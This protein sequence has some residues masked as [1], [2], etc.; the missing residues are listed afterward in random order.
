MPFASPEITNAKTFNE[1]IVMK[2][3]IAMRNAG[4]VLGTLLVISLIAVPAFAGCGHGPGMMRGGG[5]GY[6]PYSNLTQEQITQ[7]NALHQN[8][9]KDT[10][11]L[12]DDLWAKRHD[13]SEL[14]EASKPDL[15]KA[16][17]LQQQVSA[18]EA[19]IDQ[20]KIEYIVSAHKIAPELGFFGL[21]FGFGHYRHGRHMM[22]ERGC[23]CGG[24]G[25]GG[26]WAH[27]YGH[28]GYGPGGYG[29]GWRGGSCSR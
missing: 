22:M 15:Q 8:F 13:L 4:I 17:D 21:G 20:K 9:F 25:Y 23:G 14:M 1:T 10:D 12:R 24:E 3:R 28:G 18:V 7:L 19:Q 16:K 5:G 6:G 29:P 11:K 2:R 27:G 26:E